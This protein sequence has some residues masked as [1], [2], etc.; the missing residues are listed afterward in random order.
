MSYDLH[1]FG[2]RHLDR[3]AVAN[4]CASGDLT[5]DE[6]ASGEGLLVVVRGARRRYCF[7][8]GLAAE[9]EP[10]DV[11]EDV[12]ALVLEP[13]YFYELAVEGSSASEVPHAIRF[14]RKLAH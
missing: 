7:T 8:V 13:R 1:V 12:A 5:V 4:L 14:A 6:Q 2:R 11:S 9:I 3:A 10:E